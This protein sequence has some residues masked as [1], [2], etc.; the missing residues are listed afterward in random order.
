MLAFGGMEIVVD[1]EQIELP[2]T[3]TYKGM[4]LSGVPNLA[5]AFGYTNASWTLKCDLTCEYVCRLLNYMDAHGYREC[6]PSER[7][8]SM[9]EEPFIDFSSGYV[10]RAI[11]KFPKQG[12]RAPWRLYQNYALDILSLRFGSVEDSAMEFSRNGAAMAGVA[13]ELAAEGALPDT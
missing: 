6:R 1:G 9:P 11:D 7:D 10:L 5:L 13:H 8:P 4:M 3:M 2:Q 12:A